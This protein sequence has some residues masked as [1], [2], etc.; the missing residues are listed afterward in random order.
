MLRIY[1]TPPSRSVRIV[2]LAEE[3]SLPY[4]AIAVP[5]GGAP[6]AGFTDASPLGQLPA[7]EDGEVRMIESVAI[8][9]YLLA[10]YGP[11]PL[12]VTKTERA[13]PDY[14]QFLEF[15]E[16][17]LTAIGNAY[18]ATRFRAPDDQK[19]NWTVDYV[20]DAMRKR[21]ALVD[22]RLADGREFIVADRFTAADIS[23]GWSVSIAKYFGILESFEPATQ[24]YYDRITARPAYAKAIAG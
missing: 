20:T 21:F 5:F 13:F 15:G 24:A 19:K 1:H 8:M 9:Q 12:E 11:S 23:V 16:A 17:G 18:V 3:M 14:L 22:R 6:P 2:W 10:K 4:E 7:I